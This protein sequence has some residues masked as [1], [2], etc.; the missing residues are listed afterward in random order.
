MIALIVFYILLIFFSFIIFNNAYKMWK[1]NQDF[2]LPISTLIIFYFTL[3][4]AFIFPLD[5]FLG[6]K[7]EAIG[8]HYLPIFDRL[9]PVAFDSDYFISCAYYVLFVLVFQ[10]TYILFVKKFIRVNKI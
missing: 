3:A 9:F 6:F 4:G 10:Y 7:G 1:V 8:I 5:A 2:T